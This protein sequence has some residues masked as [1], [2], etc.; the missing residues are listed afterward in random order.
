MAFGVGV[1]L[2]SCVGT[3]RNHIKFNLLP[4]RRRIFCVSVGLGFR[5]D[6]DDVLEDNKIITP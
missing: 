4:S 6:E 1:G 5:H 2:A 3:E